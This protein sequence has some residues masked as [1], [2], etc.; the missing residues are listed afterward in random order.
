MAANLGE[1]WA[2]RYALLVIAGTL[3]V[4]VTLFRR[5][6]IPWLEEQGSGSRL[7]WLAG[8][9]A[10]TATLIC[11]GIVLRGTTPVALI[12]ALLV[13]PLRQASVWTVALV[14]PPGNRKIALLS[15][16]VCLYVT[17]VRRR[18]ARR[19]GPGEILTAGAGLLRLAVGV[20]FAASV[21]AYYQD[22]PVGFLLA[23]LAWVAAFPPSGQT[24]RPEMSYARFLLPPLALLAALHAYPVAGSHI[25]WS[26]FL[27]IPIAGICV[28]DGWGQIAR[29]ARARE[30]WAAV[31]VRWLSPVMALAAVG[32][33]ACSVVLPLQGERDR[34]RDGKALSLPGSSRI[35]LAPE[36][37][38]TLLWVSQEIGQHCKTFISLPGMNSFYFWTRQEPATM[39]NV[40]T[41]MYLFPPAMQDRVLERIRGVDGLCVLRND[42]LLAIWAR[43]RPLPDTALLRYLTGGFVPLEERGGYQI[44]VRRPEPALSP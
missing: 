12:Q 14:L 40:G 16:G 15:L 36:Q 41:W 3:A 8:G 34:F 37:A 44:L 43:G 33:I 19:E 17:A 39:L 6:P 5:G 26:S 38:D 10:G 11:A 22:R 31:M 4:A 21:P 28:Y 30:G 1:S 13:L 20:A 25:S 2:Q 23:P 7:L 27:F 24:D 29:W 32:L 42:N 18:P 35:R 9:A